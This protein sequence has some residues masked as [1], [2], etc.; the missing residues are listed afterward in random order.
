MGARYTLCVWSIFILKEH[1]EKM[2]LIQ[3]LGKRGFAGRTKPQFPWKNEVPLQVVDIMW[4]SKFPSGHHPT[5]G[6]QLCLRAH[7]E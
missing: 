5:W 1:R 2:W 6:N 4:L 7:R 3:P